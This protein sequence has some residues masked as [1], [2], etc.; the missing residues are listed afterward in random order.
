METV[1]SAKSKLTLLFIVSLLVTI[2]SVL[3][4]LLH[5]EDGDN[6][7]SFSLQDTRGNAVTEAS[8][9]GRWSVLVFGFTHC[10]DICPSQ[11][12][13]ISESLNLFDKNDGSVHVQGVFISVDYLRDRGEYLDQYLNHFHSRF[14]GFLGSKLQLDLVVDAFDASYSVAKLK[15]ASG[16]VQV[17]HSSTI[18]LIDPEGRIAKQLPFTTS[19]KTLAK[20]LSTLI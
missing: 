8:L 12:L 4:I 13:T 2:G 17:T 1:V 10:P 14:V 9:K 6:R 20:T 7:V 18:Y 16:G 3:F 11:A 5:H 15:G 19:A